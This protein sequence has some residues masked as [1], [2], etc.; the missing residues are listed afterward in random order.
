MYA[1]LDRGNGVGTFD[2]LGTRA[3]RQGRG[4][5]TDN[6]NIS[7]SSAPAASGE[8]RLQRQPTKACE[9]CYPR[10][11]LPH[12]VGRSGWAHEIRHKSSRRVRRFIPRQRRPP[13]VGRPPRR[14]AARRPAVQATTPRRQPP[15]HAAARRGGPPGTW[16]TL[17]D[18][19]GQNPAFCGCFRQGNNA[20]APPPW[21]PRASF[22]PD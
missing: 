15:R 1:L 9:K 4:T 3:R 20:R 14:A 11:L 7:L 13:P 16:R 5:T 17:E 10:G 18:P 12:G 2:P 6:S 22:N 19:G 8:R 21:P